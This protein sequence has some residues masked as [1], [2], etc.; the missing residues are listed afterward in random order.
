MDHFLPNCVSAV[1]VPLLDGSMPRAARSRSPAVG[2]L[3]GW[4]LREFQV[5]PITW[6]IGLATFSGRLR[7]W[8]FGLLDARIAVMQ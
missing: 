5:F 7:M 1:F 8:G 2:K 3:D 4:G 6:F